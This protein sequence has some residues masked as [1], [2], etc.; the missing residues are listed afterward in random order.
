MRI[1]SNPLIRKYFLGIILAGFIVILF[2]R[3]NSMAIARAQSPGAESFRTTK[4]QIEALEPTEAPG[5]AIETSNPESWN[6][7]IDPYWAFKISYPSDWILQSSPSRDFGW[8]VYSPDLNMDPVG[9][10]LT[11]GYLSVD[12]REFNGNIFQ[13]EELFEAKIISETQVII[14]GI[15]A[16]EIEGI[17][18]YGNH[19]K[20]IYFEIRGFSYYIKI[21]TELTEFDEISLETEK[22]IESFFILGD[23]INQP[24]PPPSNLQILALNFLG[25]KLPFQSGSGKITNGYNDGYYHTGGDLYAMDFIECKGIVSNLCY[26]GQSG[27]NVIAPTDITLIWSGNYNGVTGDENDFHIFEITSDSSQKLCMSLAHFYLSSSGRISRGTAMGILAPYSYSSPHYHMGMWI[28]PL[29][30]SCAGSSRSPIPYTGAYRLDGVEYLIGQNHANKSVVSSNTTIDWTLSY[31][32]PIY[33]INALVTYNGLLFAGGEDANQTNGRIYKF[34]GTTWT[35]INFASQIGITVNSIKTFIVFE[36]KI[37]IGTRVDIGGVKYGRIFSYDGLNFIQEF[38]APGLDGYSGITDLTIHNNT[39]FAANGS[40]VGEVYKR[41]GSGDWDTVGSAIEAGI[42]VHAL[43]SYAG[44]LY[45]GTGANGYHPK[46]WKWT[47]ALWS[48]YGDLFADFGILQN[49]VVSLASAYG[50]LF[51]GF[52]GSGSSNPIFRNDGS[53]WIKNI[54]INNCTSSYLDVIDGFTLAGTNCNPQAYILEREKYLEMGNTGELAIVEFALYNGSIYAGTIGNGKIFV[55]KRVRFRPITNDY[56]GDGKTDPVKFDPAT[57][58]AWWLKSS[59]GLWDG[60]WLGGDAFTYVN[61]SDFDGDGKTDSAKFY[62]GT[63]T[64]WWIKSSTST[65]GGQWLGPDIFNYITGSDFDGDGKSDPAKF[66]PATGTVWWVKSTTG[67]MGGQWLGADTFQYVTG[68]D[69]D[70]DGKTDP[71]KFYPSTGTVWWVKSSTG[72]MG[73]MWLGADSFTYVP[74]SDFDGDG[75]TDPS[76]FYSSTGTVWWVK[77][78]TGGMEGAWLGSGTFTYV[79]GCDFDGDGK[80]DPTKYDSNTHILSWLGSSTGLWTFVDMGVGVYILANGQ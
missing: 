34:N 2:S 77:S 45:A 66:Y 11:G 30:S 57:G 43:A 27:Q 67:T 25:I 60:K 19:F 5:T 24:V 38:S 62:S 26:Q 58:I 59:T 12:I 56:D 21:V 29:A 75:K 52:D 76:K 31:D 79:S 74:A 7:F 55:H 80:T 48:N 42:P 64:V 72:T 15:N 65:I 33:A 32:S 53:N 16:S 35:D 49:S 44:S 20:S 18:I 14:T 61:G 6:E 68:S 9:R 63:G 1:T 47:G 54:E 3:E 37:F 17:T 50:Y 8:R 51:A 71:A 28:A 36:N 46:V 78:S 41:I 73:G 70:G 40:P 4:K 10:P 69:F 23:P 22:I 13:D 39:L